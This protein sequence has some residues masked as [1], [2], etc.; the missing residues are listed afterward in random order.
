M[1]WREQHQQASFRGVPFQV[2]LDEDERGR[3]LVVHEFPGR[4]KPYL[5][6]MGRTPNRFTLE[7]FCVGD[8][9]LDQAEALQ[10]ECLKPGPGELVH[11]WYGKM[12]VECE[13]IRI[14]HE[15]TELRM[16]RVSLAFLEIGEIQAVKRVVNTQAR[17][18]VSAQAV[19]DAQREEFTAAFRFIDQPYSAAQKL[20][21]Q[22]RAAID[23]VSRSRDQVAQSAAYVQR[24]QALRSQI[25]TLVYSAAN[26]AEEFIALITLGLL[27]EAADQSPDPRTVYKGLAPL[28]TFAPVGLTDSGP[29]T[30]FG[31]LIRGVA[32]AQGGHVLSLVEFESIEEAGE[33]KTRL[34]DAMDVLTLDGVPDTLFSAVHDL[35]AAV[36]R[37]VSERAVQLPRVVELTLPDFTSALLLSYQLYGTVAEE[38]SILRRNRI[39]HPG[40]LPSDVPLK[41]VTDA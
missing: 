16:T 14:R 9:H 25:E 2:T 39:E 31:Q 3:R 26:L 5:E 30:A 33:M 6:G 22:V 29:G 37:D 21:N 18:A 13:S 12:Q 4:D 11:P 36:E 8:D 34:Y 32:I 38:E 24:I 23:T 15:Q 40:V 35:R 1:G 19:V 7:G 17:A 27:T 20:L 28:F 41:V 10:A